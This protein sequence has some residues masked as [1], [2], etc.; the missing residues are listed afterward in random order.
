VK[1]VMAPRSATQ[2]LLCCVVC[3]EQSREKNEKKK[4]ETWNKNS[5][6]A[7]GRAVLLSHLPE[8]AD[9]QGR[10]IPTRKRAAAVQP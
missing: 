2:R 10:E 6:V 5:T 9:P 3:L 4:K 7:L 8:P 1:P